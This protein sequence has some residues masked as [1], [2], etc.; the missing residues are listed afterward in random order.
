[1]MK[2]I[3]IN[4]NTTERLVL[5]VGNET[6]YNLTVRILTPADLNNYKNID[7][8][9]SEIRKKEQKDW[10][11]D[12]QQ[13]AVNVITEILDYMIIESD[14]DKNK[15]L[16]MPLSALTQIHKQIKDMQGIIDDAK[17]KY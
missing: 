17:K 9:L 4:A 7:N 13:L 2:E 6:K 14:V 3:K 16:S 5:D 15:I 10:T 12:D 8:K 1:M 11:F